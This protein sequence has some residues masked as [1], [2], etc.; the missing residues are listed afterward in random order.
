MFFPSLEEGAPLVCY[1]AG[2]CGL[3]IVTGPMGQGRLVEHGVTGFVADPHD[4]DALASYIRTLAENELLR[5]EMGQRIRER[6]LKLDF[7]SAAA[8]RARAFANK[9]L[10]DGSA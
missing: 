10:A 9:G 4:E 7:R 5:K 3:P 1:Q 6:A 2:G 8:D